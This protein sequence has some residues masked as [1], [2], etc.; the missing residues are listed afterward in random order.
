ME[1]FTTNTV[2]HLEKN[3]NNGASTASRLQKIVSKGVH[4]CSVCG[5]DDNSATLSH[6]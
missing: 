5:R 2:G 3:T 6:A 4:F 1:N